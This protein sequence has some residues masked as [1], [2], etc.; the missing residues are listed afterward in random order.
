VACIKLAAASGALS[1]KYLTNKVELVLREAEKSGTS[2]MAAL[3]QLI[4]ENEHSP[5]LD[6]LR[7]IRYHVAAIIYNR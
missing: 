3:D 1:D 6:H 5:V 7:S 4:K 2:A